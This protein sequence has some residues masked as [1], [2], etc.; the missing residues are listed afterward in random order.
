M[1]IIKKSSKINKEGFLNYLSN[2]EIMICQ[3]KRSDKNIFIYV[4]KLQNECLDQHCI[5]LIKFNITFNG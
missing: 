1:S 5:G 2:N 3:N 4:S